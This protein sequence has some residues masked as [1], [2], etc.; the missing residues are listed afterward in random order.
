M[1]D[2][3]NIADRRK[4]VLLSKFLAHD[5]LTTMDNKLK[6]LEE[7][8]ENIKKR[9]SRVEAEKAWE[10]SSVRSI[11]ILILTY[12]LVVITMLILKID[13]SFINALIPTLGY[14][15]S[16][17]SLPFVKKY[18]IKRYLRK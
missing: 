6:E 1:N 5:I 14:F 10:T 13:R 4:R 8:I 11:T 7:D 15:L 3:K 12:V 17:Q 2:S 9:N 16:I 18:W